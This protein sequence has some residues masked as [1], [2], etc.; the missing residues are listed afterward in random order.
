MNISFYTA[1]TGAIQ[2]QGRLDVHGN[3]IANVNTYGFKA[4][5]PTFTQLMT[6]E[7]PS[8][9]EYLPRGVGA[10]MIQADT[11]FS[12][13]ING[14]AGTD[15]D[16]DY[17]INGDGFFALLDPMTGEFSY[18]R[19]GSFTISSFQETETVDTYD[20]N[21]NITG[22][23]QQQVTNW[24]LSDGR[25]RFVLGTDGAP[26]QVEDP[27][28][29][30]RD[31]LPI[32]IFDFVNT[33]GMQSL[34]DNRFAPVEKNGQVRLGTGKLVQGYLEASNTDL[35]YELAKVVETQRTFSYLLRMITV[36]DEIES[37]VNSLR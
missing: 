34:S 20:E 22:Q 16:L 15:L 21:G 18:T 35:G 32:G 30:Q 25:G 10:R 2:Q 14:F 23:E 31:P 26:I 24:Y 5:K 28:A 12:E 37:T 33:D 11:D 8:I 13:S 1:T 29:T 19:D 17:A 4:K 9:E 6:Q 36:S 27:Q 7:I 3:N